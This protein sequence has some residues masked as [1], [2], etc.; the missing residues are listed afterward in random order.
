MP[1]CP[2]WISPGQN[3]IGGSSCQGT[4]NS[5]SV[6]FRDNLKSKAVALADNTK[7]SLANFP[8]EVG[9]DKS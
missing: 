8:L 5:P 4:I 6:I 2:S 9:L 7:F 1:S 3:K